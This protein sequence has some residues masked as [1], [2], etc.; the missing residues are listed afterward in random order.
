MQRS[1]VD[2]PDPDP[3]I[4]TTT[5]PS[6]TVQVDPVED[7]VV[8]EVL[9]H[10]ADFENRPVIRPHPPAA[11]GRLARTQQSASRPVGMA[12]RMNRTAAITYGV[13]LKVDVVVDRRLLNRVD[14]AADDRD[15]PDVLLQRRR[16]R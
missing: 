1:N 12:S 6:S 16:S 10:P 3:P 5:S 7:P 4:S 13:K 15:Q 9:V 14:G 2:L 8:A 11:D